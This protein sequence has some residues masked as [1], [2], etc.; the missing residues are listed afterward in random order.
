MKSQVR[1][2]QK[3]IKQQK[4]F[5]SNFDLEVESLKDQLDNEITK[6]AK[7]EKKVRKFVKWLHK[8]QKI[9]IENLISKLGIEE[10]RKPKHR[11]PSS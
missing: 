4:G 1:A 7:I 9:Y 11:R 10:V 2:Y 6:R 8:D 3:I 5:Q